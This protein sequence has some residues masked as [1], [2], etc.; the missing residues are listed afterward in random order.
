MAKPPLANVL[1]DAVFRTF[2]GDE[3]ESI[4]GIGGYCRLSNHQTPGAEKEADIASYLDPGSYVST[5]VP[6]FSIMTGRRTSDY[7]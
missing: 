2:G 7:V 1:P 4:P 3:T 6:E 5:L